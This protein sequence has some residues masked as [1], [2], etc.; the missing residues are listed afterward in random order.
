MAFERSRS[1]PA[2]YKRAGV[3]QR[4]CV[5]LDDVPPGEP[6]AQSF[7][8][9]ANHSQDFG[10]T[11]RDRMQRYEACAP[12]LAAEA[13]RKA[14]TEAALQPDAIT[15][16][17]TVS[18]SGF[19]A[20]GFDLQ[21]FPSLG[22][23]PNVSRTHVGFMGCHGAMNGLR[24][25][26]AYA[27]ADPNARVLVCCVELC[28]LH[29]QYTEDPQQLVAN[30]LFSDGAAALVVQQANGPE[31]TSS[32]VEAW[33]VASQGSYVIPE[34]Q[35]MMSWRIADHGFRMTLSPM[36]P[37]IIVDSLKGWL[38]P[39]LAR[40]DLKIDDI[41]GWAIHPGGPRILKACAE[42][43]SLPPDA[44]KDSEGILANYGNM[45]SPTVL[46]IVDQI[47]QRPEVRNCVTL[48]FGPGLTIE[49]ALLRR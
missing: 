47:R 3:K 12:D 6:A 42:A 38:D 43:L 5:V 33:T 16:L 41:D 1:L 7:Y 4:H 32:E 39:W 13:C 17:V 30:T 24:V 36:V 22:L 28:S 19:N 15:H 2:L 45:S 37:Q 23:P 14:L 20:P 48:G 40:A 8:G 35:E 18:C 27:A 31:D 10:P 26:Q 9:K 44:L 49:A 46:F 34:T 21:L 29:H 11:T 25:A